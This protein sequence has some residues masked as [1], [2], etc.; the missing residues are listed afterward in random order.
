MLYSPIINHINQTYTLHSNRYICLP[1]ATKEEEE[2]EARLRQQQARINEGDET[3]SQEDANAAAHF[4][5]ADWRAWMRRLALKRLISPI[6]L[7]PRER[8]ELAQ[9]LSATTTITAAASHAMSSST[10]STLSIVVN[11]SSNMSIE[12]LLYQ[13]KIFLVNQT[14][15]LLVLFTFGA[16]SPLLSLVIVT[17][18]L[19]HSIH[20]TLV[21]GR[22]VQK[23]AEFEKRGERQGALGGIDELNE[24]CR[25]VNYHFLYK[26]RWLLLML[27]SSIFSFFLMD[28]FGDVVGYHD[29][30]APFLLMLFS[31]LLIFLFERVLTSLSSQTSSSPIQTSSTATAMTDALG[32]ELKATTTT[33]TTN[34]L[35]E[36]AAAV[37]TLNAAEEEARMGQVEQGDVIPTRIQL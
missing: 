13:P 9:Q 15:N 34:P 3:S 30:L 36:P 4:C 6:L 28:T 20:I 25:Q 26:M 33:T 32:L 22:F 29:A 21:F 19:T 17:A 8:I 18:M 16:T 37:A 2:E 11:Q 10:D 24:A 14:T 27:S 31:P 7:T 12:L 5:G 23:E 1:E 35:C